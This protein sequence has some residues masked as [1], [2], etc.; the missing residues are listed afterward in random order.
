MDNNNWS[1]KYHK[2]ITS[3]SGEDGI[4]ERMFEIIPG[5]D[6]WCCEFGAWDG[7]KYSNTY[8]LLA[9]KGWSGVLI[10]AD[11][12][13]FKELPVTFGD[14]KKITFLN[15]YVQ[16]AG[17]DILD[18]LLAETPIPIDFDLLS[19][20]IDGN[21]YHV[22]QAVTKYKPKVVIIEFNQSIP[23]HVE[24]VQEPDPRNNH[25]N[26]LLSI[27]KLGKAKGYELVAVTELNAILARKEYFELFGMDDNSVGKLRPHA[28]YV[29]DIF[30]LY[31]GT[32]VLSG[33][34]KMIWHGVPMKDAKFQVVPKYLRTF[35]G[36]M[37]KFKRILL[38]I[39]KLAVG[40]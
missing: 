39:W 8:Q 13:K 37:G 23:N 40:G 11:P 36:L 27:V 35:P 3:Q 28:P 1:E 5:D 38:K 6:R 32:I 9:N 33:Y 30:Q 24:F 22:W 20:D 16:F 25:G 4:L 15:K 14:N 12:E 7:K 21:D 10:E 17:K 18:D 34:K 26:S 19:I 2:N 31:D 29:T